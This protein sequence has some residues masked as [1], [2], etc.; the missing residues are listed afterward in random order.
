MTVDDYT[1]SAIVRPFIAD[2]ITY[3]YKYQQVTI[4]M[5]GDNTV[6]YEMHDVLNKIYNEEELEAMRKP[7]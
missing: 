4:K 3:D 6:T 2:Y 5:T 1:Y 7:L